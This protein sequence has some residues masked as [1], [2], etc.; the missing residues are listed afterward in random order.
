MDSKDSPILHLHAEFLK[1]R[2]EGGF[3]SDEVMMKWF[4][5]RYSVSKHLLTLYSIARG[6]NAKNILEIGGGRSTCVL[7]KAAYENGGKL[8]SCD[9]VNIGA[10]LSDDEKNVTE[11]LLGKSELVWSRPEGY[12]FAFL[13]YFSN[14][15]LNIFYIEKE[16]NKCIKKM[17][18]NGVIAIHDAYIKKYSQIHD[19]FKRIVKKRKDVEFTIL[20]FNYGLGIIRCKAKSV[21]GKCDCKYYS[22]KI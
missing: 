1:D 10:L 4:N 13:D 9:M 21:Y 3:I 18:K 19:V 22:Y 7:S 17:K 11:F 6:L 5:E 15:D 8:I 20:P 16:I 2:S 12:D 14:R